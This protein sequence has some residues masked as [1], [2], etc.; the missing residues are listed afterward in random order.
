MQNDRIEQIKG[1]GGVQ[2]QK[3]DSVI[4]EFILKTYLFRLQYFLQ[5][6][7]ILIFREVM[8]FQS[9]KGVIG[10]ILVYIRIIGGGI[11][12]FRA[13]LGHF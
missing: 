6:E 4:N 5:N 8:H 3:I 11:V 13:F 10:Y 12:I 9:W 1:I 7:K 2:V